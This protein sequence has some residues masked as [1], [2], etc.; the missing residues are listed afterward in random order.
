MRCSPS[1]V[2]EVIQDMPEN[3]KQRIR[4]LGFGEL[5]HFKIDKLEDRV[6]GMFLMS[7]I[8]DN[9]LR[10]DVSSKVLPITPLA[11]H[12]VFGIPLGGQRFYT[13]EH[14]MKSRG[15]SELRQICDHNG[16]K[17]NV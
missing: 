9:P 6:L 4:D 1:V 17:K 5:L 3:L 11:V 7:N 13:Y 16:M 10:I 14:K 8:K 2:R 15:R 12:K